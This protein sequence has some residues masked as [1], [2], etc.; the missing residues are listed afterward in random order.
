MYRI[1]L[2]FEYKN[3][4]GCILQTCKKLPKFHNREAEIGPFYGVNYTNNRYVWY[5]QSQLEEILNDS[6]L[7]PYMF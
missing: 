1:G 7:Y 2:S 5:S 3:D 6:T 4:K